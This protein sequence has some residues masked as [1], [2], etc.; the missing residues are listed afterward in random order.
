MSCTIL[1]CITGNVLYKLDHIWVSIPWKTTLNR[2]KTIAPITFESLWNEIQNCCLQ[3]NYLGYVVLQGLSFVI[4]LEE[5]IK[6][7]HRVWSKILMKMGH[8]NFFFFKLYFRHFL[9]QFKNRN[10]C[11]VWQWYASL[12]KILSKFELIKAHLSSF[13]LI[14]LSSLRPIL[15]WPTVE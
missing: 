10:I 8:N 7:R 9:R 13:R 5:Y 15:M 4:K 11:H 12:V 2:F 14:H 1:R 3:E 6:G